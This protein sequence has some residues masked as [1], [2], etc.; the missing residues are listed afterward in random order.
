MRITSRLTF[1]L[2]LSLAAPHFAA[3]QQQIDSGAHPGDRIYLDVVVTPQSGPAITNLRQQDFTILDNNIPQP[4]TSFESIE[5][6]QAHLS[7]F[8]IFD[9]LNLTP[10]AKGTAFEDI[11]RF[12]TTN[13]GELP[14]PT[15]IDFVTDKG[16]QYIAGPSRDGKTLSSSFDKNSVQAHLL[17]EP[18]ASYPIFNAFAEFVAL[19][20]NKPGR[21]VVLFVS[22]GWP[23]VRR[24]DF[25]NAATA[26]EVRELRQQ[27]FENVVQLTKQL[28]DAQIT[29]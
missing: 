19:E 1:F 16:L 10:R 28:R 5:A 3:S 20:R 22:R 25:D 26:K 17:A 7:L 8:I 18:V 13:G 4:I 14:Y 9:A 11:K 24:A 23:P 27:M 6:Q 29:V 15:T 12:L 2:A 21:K